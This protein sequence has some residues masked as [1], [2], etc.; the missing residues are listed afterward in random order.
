M[1]FTENQ[2]RKIEILLQDGK[3]INDLTDLINFVL[4]CQNE[5]LQTNYTSISSKQLAYYTAKR[6]EK[7]IHFKIPKKTGGSR[8]I[9]TPFPFLKHVQKQFNIILSLFF[10]PRSSANGFV[11]K[12]NILTNAEKHIGKKYVYNIDIQDFFPTVHY[13]RIKAV[14]QLDPFYVS[15]EL[16][17]LI[18]H[19]TCFKK[20]LPQRAP[21]SPLL[22]NAVCQSLDRLLVDLAK[23]YRCYY[24]RYV[25]DITFSSNQNKFE[26]GNFVK[27][28]KEII[29]QQGFRINAKKTRLQ[30]STQP[31]EVTG[32][33]VNKKLNLT[34][35]YIKKVRAMLN[36]W[37]KKDFHIVKVNFPNTIS[38][39]KKPKRINLFRL[40]KLF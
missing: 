9:S 2:I 21:T 18:A 19:L 11:K 20:I 34:K 5:I 3:S 10:V 23:H 22:I 28:L 7:Y 33:V 38:E 39:K 12:R 24:S 32:V 1:D 30:R 29:Q 40:S 17:H 26:K 37:K 6:D 36:N 15:L 35:N 4:R 8:T 27:D 25:D 13:G 16:A 14:F 31:Q